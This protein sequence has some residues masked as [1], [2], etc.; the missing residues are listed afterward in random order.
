MKRRF[1]RLATLTCL[2]LIVSLL[3]SSCATQ[4]KRYKGYPPCPC[5]GK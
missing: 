4:K 5:E 3:A 1:P 2:L